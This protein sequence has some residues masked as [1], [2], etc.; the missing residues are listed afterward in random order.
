VN[1]LINFFNPN[2]NLDSN[3]RIALLK[4]RT[5]FLNE[6]EDDIHSFAKL[7]GALM[8]G[9]DNPINAT[10][11][12]RKCITASEDNM[13]QTIEPITNEDDNITSDETC[14]QQHDE[15]DTNVMESDTVK[16]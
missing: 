8:K 12:M 6:V 7:Q 14:E 11:E 16:V 1:C 4:A 10:E 15:C 13:E 9:R 3:D 5:E 2:E